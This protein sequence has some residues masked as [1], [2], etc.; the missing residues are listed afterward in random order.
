[1]YMKTAGMCESK[2]KSCFD[3]IDNIFPIGYSIS[4]QMAVKL[5]S[6]LNFPIGK[7]FLTQNILVT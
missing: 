4:A 3:Y 1:M 2:L 6:S 5:N 7:R